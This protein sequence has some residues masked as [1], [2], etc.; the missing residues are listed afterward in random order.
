[1]MKFDARGVVTRTPEPAGFGVEIGAPVKF[2]TMPTG[3]DIVYADI[4]SGKL[5]RLVYSPG[6]VA[7]EPEI[8]ATVDA[9]T[10]T[11][12]FD[13]TKS[14][15]PNGDPLTYTWAF[16]DGQTGAG[17]T[18]T[19]TYPAGESFE[20]AL[21]ASD[22]TKTGTTTKTVYP[23]NHAP[24]LELQ[25][26]DVSRTFAVGDLVEATAS[27]TDLED[28][29]LTVTWGMQVV[30]CSTPAECHQHP[31]ARQDGPAFGTRFEGHPGDSRLEITAVAT[32]SKGASTERTFVVRPKQRRV[33]IQS[34]A[35]ADF[36]IGD[37]QTSSGMFTVGTPLTIIAPQVALDGVSTFGKWADGSTNR[38]REVTL[39]DADQVFDVAYHSPIARR[40]SSDTTLPVRLGAPVGTEQGDAT[41]RWQVYSKGR[42][43]WSAATGVRYIKGGLLAKY[44]AVGGHLVFGLPTSDETAGKD[45]GYYNLIARD[46][47]IYWHA[48]TGAHT[49]VGAI[50]TRYRADGAEGALG[51]PTIDEGFTPSRTG[52]WCQ[53]QRG[54]ILWTAGTGAWTVRGAI[55]A[56][57]AALGYERSYL[58]YPKS[59]EFAVTGGRRSN[60]QHGYIFWNRTT[61]KVTDHR[62]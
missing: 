4:R 22:G 61:G 12:V 21:T 48:K 3:G 23:G 25:A 40:Y 57:Y 43:Y 37:E 31:G 38:V 44:L 17:A 59:N 7:P 16:G 2:G 8:T 45:G 46:R 41:V 13:A 50:H 15:D 10:R 30:H 36:T 55:R 51:Y 58:G 28:G 39:P 33:T 54:T 29:P 60:F 47:G 5:R 11:V 52:H 27:A 6:N 14:V 19:H 9:D 34:N 24:A 26:P 35:A 62:Y 56:R 42:M 32:D 49:V 53:F 20:V 1:S 18:V